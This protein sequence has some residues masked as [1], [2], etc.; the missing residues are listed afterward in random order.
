[1]EVKAGPFETF[2]LSGFGGGYEDMCQRMLWRGVGWLAEAEPPV[3]MWSQAKSYAGVWGVVSTE[4]QNLKAL[5]AA[6]IRPG[7]DVTG[8]MHQCVMGHL[9]FIHRNGIDAWREHMRQHRDGSFE[10]EGVL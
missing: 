8:A 3:E 9:A 6:I 4:G 5:E 1:V 7:D 2:D 10:W